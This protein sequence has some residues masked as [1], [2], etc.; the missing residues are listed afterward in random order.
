VVAIGP[1]APHQAARLAP[2]MPFPLYLDPEHRVQG[3]LGARRQSRLAYLFNIR[4]WL[5]YLAALVRHRRQGWPTG[6][7]ETL[8]SVAI[9]SRDRKVLWQF[10]GRS[11]ADYPSLNE[12]V[13]RLR[14][15]GAAAAG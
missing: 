13:D 3:I 1:A 5:R 9:V 7:Y 14:E 11:I 4:G 2:R 6:R 8:P 12:L 10:Q 15:H